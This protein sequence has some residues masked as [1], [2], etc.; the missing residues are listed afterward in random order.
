MTAL[1]Q[2]DSK[3]LLSFHVIGQIGYML[4]AVGIG[5]YFLP[6]NMY[7]AT[8]ALIAGIFHLANN[9]LYK[10]SLFL[11]AGSNIWLIRSS[12]VSALGTV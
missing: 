9:A 2:D 10:S 5:I 7:I 4:L 1:V 6:T 11:S 8:A 12:R 3:R